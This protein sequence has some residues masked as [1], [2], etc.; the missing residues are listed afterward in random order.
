MRFFRRRSSL[1]LLA[2][3]A[4]AMQAMLA[5]AQTH[6]H[7]HPLAQS[8]AAAGSLAT[9]AI[10]YGACAAR[11]AHPCRPSI[12]HDDRGHCP[13]CWSVNLAS[14]A[15]LHQPPAIPHLPPRFAAPP[16]LRAV[17]FSCGD[18]SVHFQARA[19]PSLTA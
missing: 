9:R 18:E 1:G 2:P 15:I 4:F 13:V 19:P 8:Q 10:T 3:L 7:T 5:L 16:P 6:V 11:A 17:H 14:S 12:P